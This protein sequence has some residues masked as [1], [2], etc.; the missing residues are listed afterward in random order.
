MP[1]AVRFYV[2]LH[3]P[4]DAQHVGRCMVSYA[5]LRNRRGDFAVGEWLLD[6]GAF[7]EVARHGGYRDAPEVYAA[8]VV[9]WSRCGQL[10]AAVAQDYMCEPFVLARTGLSLAEHQRLTIA[11]YDALR[12]LVPAHIHLMPV[13]QGYLPE[14]YAAHVAAYGARLR[15]GMWAGVGSVCKRNARPGDAAA[16]LRAVRAARPDL[17]LHAF[18]LKLTALESPEV[19]GLLWSADSLAWSYAARREG[20]DANDWREAA[21]YA[22][23]VAAWQPPPPLP[24]FAGLDEAA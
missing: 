2:G 18:G 23:R 16:V 24:L 22:A 14:H 17:R 4:S 11:R 9:R 12:A 21:A 19:R 8:A 13:L 1:N 10:A 15:P 6:S 3:Q 5:R 20:R 7:S